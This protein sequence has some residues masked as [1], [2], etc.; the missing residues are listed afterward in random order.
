MFSA[1]ALSA[2]GHF[3]RA[4]PLATDALA[5]CR[6]LFPETHPQVAEA[7]YFVAVTYLEADRP[8]E[9]LPH[10]L[11]N[12]A[13]LQQV[14]APN[15][16]HLADAFDLVGIIERE[17]GHPEKALE[18]HQSALQQRASTSPN[19][20]QTY[21]YLGEA[22]RSLGEKEQAREHLERSLAV[23][24]EALPYARAE[25]AFALAQVISDRNRAAGLLREMAALPNAPGT[26]SFHLRLEML[27]WAS[28]HHVPSE[29]LKK[30]P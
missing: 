13:I 25:M 1:Q 28:Q 20:W 8:A 24:H 21:G 7:H 10:A 18:R 5:R 3:D 9:A 2:L 23:T 14:V 22:E 17:L 15:R 12:L 6:K 11:R 4:L 29:L 27:R 30:Q 26:R 19:I 16:E